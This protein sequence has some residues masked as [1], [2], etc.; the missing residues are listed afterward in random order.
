MERYEKKR[1]KRLYKEDDLGGVQEIV[2]EFLVTERDKFKKNKFY[3][4]KQLVKGY[5]GDAL[6]FNFTEDE[7]EDNFK[8]D[9][10]PKEEEYVRYNQDL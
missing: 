6:W 8:K 3:F 10:L 5:D 9:R 4:P 2:Q 1:S 7:D